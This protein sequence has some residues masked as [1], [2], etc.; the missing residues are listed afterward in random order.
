M[1]F[2]GGIL[3][4]ALY[5][6]QQLG[7]MLGVGAETILLIS[8]LS[9]LRDSRIDESEERFAHA[10]FRVL[11]FSFFLIIVTGIGAVALHYYV[12]QLH[13]LLAPAFIL[14]W[15][16]IGIMLVLA[17]YLQ[18]KDPLKANPFVHG[19]SGATWYALFI[20]HIIAPISPWTPL[21]MLYGGWLVLFCVAWWAI[22]VTIRF[23]GITTVSGSTP[24]NPQP[25]PGPAAQPARAP[26][27]PQAPLQPR[28]SAQSSNPPPVQAKVAPAQ[29]KSQPQP[30]SRPR[31]QIPPQPKPQP[32]PAPAVSVPTTVPSLSKP[33][34]TV[35]S[36]TPQFKPGFIAP[37]VKVD[38]PPVPPRPMPAP[39]P[40]PPAP[41]QK[42]APVPQNLPVM[43]GLRLPTPPEPE[44]VPMPPVPPAPKG[45][46]ES[47]A[48][49]TDDLVPAIRIMPK[50]P[51]DV[52][53][54][55]RGSVVKFT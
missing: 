8:Y 24:R 4:L 22:F 35:A 34:P 11:W 13:I 12:G 53:N 47:Q 2:G 55:N 16:F 46:T 28:I 21:T 39:V 25:I 40:K 7:V 26:Q 32:Q 14:K 43:S 17:V 33:L 51:E 5:A 10:V 52:R 18:V 23:N 41:V 6:G 48:Q 44:I 30:Q 38:V 37:P 3:A 42:K 15:I 1:L 31:V 49:E 54:Q 29:P 45:M 19:V 36:L 9:A 50:R 20:L 27:S